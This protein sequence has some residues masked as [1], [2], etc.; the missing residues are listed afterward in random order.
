MRTTATGPM[1]PSSPVP[2]AASLATLAE[3]EAGDV[4]G[5]VD[6]MGQR[7]CQGLG[8]LAEAAGWKVTLSGPPSVPF[9]TFSDD[10]GSFKRSY[11]FYGMCA[12]RG[13]FLHPTHN[14]FLSAAHSESDIDETL[15]VAEVA[16][17]RLE[18]KRDSSSQ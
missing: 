7:L 3:I 13:V 9:M 15:E 14:W 12:E 17:S 4:I 11:A 2:I 6:R 8:R 18:E 1:S 5:H 16:F 10:M